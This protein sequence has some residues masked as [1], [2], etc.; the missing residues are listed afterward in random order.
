MKIFS[1]AICGLALVALTAGWLM[2]FHSPASAL[3]WCYHGDG[4]SAWCNSCW[5]AG[6]P[7]FCREHGYGN[8][9]CC[10]TSSQNPAYYQCTGGCPFPVQN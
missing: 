7:F 8:P 3:D 2:L 4:Q 9:W 5:N 10:Y 6:R 1:A